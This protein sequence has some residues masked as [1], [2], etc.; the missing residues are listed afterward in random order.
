MLYSSVLFCS[1]SVNEFSILVCNMGHFLTRKKFAKEAEV[2]KVHIQENFD[3]PTLKHNN[4]QV[5]S[6]SVRNGK[7]GAP[8]CSETR[9][10]IIL[11]K[12]DFAGDR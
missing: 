6:S 4:V 11:F 8:G 7:M 2:E 3:T 12:L 5:Y 1:S 9:I 10:K